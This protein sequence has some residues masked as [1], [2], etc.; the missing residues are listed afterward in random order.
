MLKHWHSLGVQGKLHILIQGSLI[1]LFAVSVPWVGGRLEDQITTA[2][3]AR[4]VEAADGLINGM[5]ML[6][7]TGTIS[8][9]ENR[10]LLL[11]KMSLSRDIRELRIIRAKQVQDQ[12]GPGLPEEQVVDEIDRRVIETGRT[13]FSQFEDAEGLP[14]LRVVVPF[15]AQE[16]FRGTNC[17]QCHHVKSGSVNGAASVVI[18]LSPQMVKVTRIKE[19][20]WSWFV[21]IQLM[22]SIIIA[23]FVRFVIVKNITRPVRKLQETMTAIQRDGDLSRRA[24]V[25][26]NNADIGAMART[27]NELTENLLTANKRLDL[28]AQVFENSGE[29]IVITDADRNIIATNPAFTE[30]TNYKPDQVQGRNPKL[31]SSGRQ[32]PEFYREMWRIINETGRWRGE[33]WNRRENGEIYPEWLSIGTVKDASGKVTNYIGI[34]NDITHR[35]QTEEHIEFL[36]H[37]DSL[38]NLPN[39]RLFED[40]VRQGLASSRRKNKKAAL[41]FLDIDRF[42]AINDSLGHLSGDQLL[43]SV[44]ERLKSCVRETDTVCRQGGDEFLIILP[45]INKPDD[46]AVVAGKIV[47]AMSEAHFVEDYHLIV[48]FSI[49]ISMFPEDGVDSQTLVKNADAAMYH[50]KEKGRNNF[51]FFTADMNAESMERLEIEADLRMAIQRNEF[52]LFY[53]PQIDS[54]SGSIIGVEALI[55]WNHPQKGYIPPTKFIPVAEECGLI[56]QIGEWVLKT[57]CRQNKAWQDADMLRVPIAVNLSALQFHKREIKDTI[58]EALHQSGLESGYLEIEVTEGTAMREISTTVRLLNEFKEMGLLISIDDFGTGY[59]SLSYL[60]RFPIDKLKV[61]QSFVRDIGRDVDDAAIVQTVIGIGHSLRLKVIAEGVETLEQ[62]T[63]LRN[64]GCD[65]IQG[66][67]FSKPLPAAEFEVF[68]KSYRA[69]KQDSSLPWMML[70]DSAHIALSEVR[71]QHQELLGMV[72]IMEQAIADNVPADVTLKMFDDLIVHVQMH[73]AAEEWL[74]QLTGYPEE[75]E[76]R[77]EHMTLLEEAQWIRRKIGKGKLDEMAFQSIK[78]WLIGHINDTDQPLIMQVMQAAKPA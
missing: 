17:L 54:R 55:R 37:Y 78:R 20:M 10:R 1:I 76:H 4:A 44:A 67:Y 61:D 35:K 70:Y 15:I 71:R 27:F 64:N 60:K 52:S 51:Q 34:F 75:S 47:T 42:K 2:A 25:D 12:F 28:F 11:R 32:T 16:D 9:P 46:A 45:E 3:N 36:A 43:Q 13:E 57:A 66:Y 23:L 30:I 29:A 65:E 22:L 14:M 24:D 6:M 33:I 58:L 68:V 62:L 31:L 69:E 26:E 59:S 74:M 72:N 49:G 18:D 5:N 19:G 41:L 73:F 56:Y 7:L 53:Q 63:F 50:A 40:R 38:T 21:V 48:T 8:N 39:R 77:T